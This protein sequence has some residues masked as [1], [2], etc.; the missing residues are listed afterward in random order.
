MF[1]A[2]PAVR[3]DHVPVKRF[4]YNES[5]RTYNLYVEGPPSSIVDISLLNKVTDPCLDPVRSY[6]LGSVVASYGPVHQLPVRVPK[7]L[8]S[9]EEEDDE[10]SCSSN[11]DDDISSEASGSEETAVEKRRIN[12]RVLKRVKIIKEKIKYFTRTT[13]KQA[14]CLNQSNNRTR[15]WNDHVLEVLE[16]VVIDMGTE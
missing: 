15:E 10:E 12:K 9:I 11:S 14:E 3:E 6:P 5:S 2:V 8:Q 16:N 4:V 13:T 1:P 7:L